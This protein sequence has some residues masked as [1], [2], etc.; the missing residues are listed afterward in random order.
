MSF[1][2]LKWLI[3]GSPTYTSGSLLHNLWSG[4]HYDIYS[5]YTDIETVV[6]F[7]KKVDTFTVLFVLLDNQ[8]PL[9]VVMWLHYKCEL[10]GGGG[11]EGGVLSGKVCYFSPATRGASFPTLKT[12]SRLPLQCRIRFPYILVLHD[13]F[14]CL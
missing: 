13:F 6:I 11:G 4:M 9:H 12:F 7:L 14:S 10:G 5:E 1:G 3:E 2:L 8:G